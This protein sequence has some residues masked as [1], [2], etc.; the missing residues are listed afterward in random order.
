MCSKFM[1]KFLARA[2]AVVVHAYIFFL[3][4]YSRELFN[5][6]SPEPHIK[7]KIKIVKRPWKS[8]YYI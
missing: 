8:K 1:F 6:V 2:I 4:V 5:H 7:K 3:S